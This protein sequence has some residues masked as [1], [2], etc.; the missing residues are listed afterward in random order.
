M[1]TI[2][3]KQGNYFLF[4]DT[5]SHLGILNCCKVA[6]EVSPGSQCFHRFPSLSAASQAADQFIQAAIVVAE[7][8]VYT[9]YCDG[10]CS[11]NGK[12][13]AHSGVGVVILDEYG[14][15]E[16]ISKR[17]L[18]PHTNQRAELT[19][20]IEGLKALPAYSTVTLFSDSQYVVNTINLK[21]RRNANHMLWD[22]LDK[23]IERH[24]K[25]TFTWIK[26]HAGHKY[27]EQADK[28]A[29]IAASSP[30][31]ANTQEH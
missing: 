14:N 5:R 13:S 6:E 23:A 21:W 11:N 10:A 31:A 17:C 30:V 8:G 27:Q 24:T 12:P 2:L 4:V 28:L 22:A 20:A 1:S 18:S 25:V 15:E 19:A 3:L 16:T 26:G 9:L 7:P 29:F